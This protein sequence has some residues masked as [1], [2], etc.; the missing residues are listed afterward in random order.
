MI[1]VIGG[2]FQGKTEFAKS[3]FCADEAEIFNAFH[4]KIRETMKNGGDI[5]AVTES[6]K[7]FKIVISD[8]VGSGIIPLDKFDRDWRETV[9]RE[10]CK[11]AACAD[12][13]WRVSCGMGQKI[14]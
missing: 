9:G 5:S 11:I 8:E 1:L 6:A 14:K 12:E 4:L 7:K 13:V 3:R 10:L 2:A